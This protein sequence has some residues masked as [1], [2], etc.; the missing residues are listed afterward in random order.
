MLKFLVTR[1]RGT[2]AGLKAYYCGFTEV[3][4]CLK[5]YASIANRLWSL[6]SWI[7]VLAVPRVLL[8]CLFPNTLKVILFKLAFE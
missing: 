3:E 5:G 8:N 6:Y 2:K 4:I 7:G 1:N